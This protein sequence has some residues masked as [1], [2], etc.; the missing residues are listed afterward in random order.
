M[1][2]YNKR[3]DNPDYRRLT[4]A[5]MGVATPSGLIADKRRTPFNI[6]RA[7]AMT[8]F[9]LHKAQPLAAGLAQKSSNPLAVLQ[10]VLD[11]TGGQP[12]LTQKV[13]QLIRS[14]EGEIIA[15]NEREWVE[16][17]V[18]SRIISHWESQDEPEH[19]K[20]IR[21]RILY[22]S[23]RKNQLLQLYRQI[24]QTGEVLST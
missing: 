20:T 18:R 1:F 7:I 4:F 2:S 21:D 8:G 6:G 23:Q 24:L 15:E 14:A 3:A 19:L 17:L 13:C 10:V 16:E 9:Q 22:S 5:L 12:F 11:W